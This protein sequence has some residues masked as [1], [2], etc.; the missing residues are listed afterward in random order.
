MFGKS[1]LPTEEMIALRA[2]DDNAGA[3]KLALCYMEKTNKSLEKHD[4]DFLLQ[5]AKLYFE[6]D[7]NELKAIDGYENHTANIMAVHPEMK[8]TGTPALN[9]CM[10]LIEKIPDNYIRYC[11]VLLLRGRCYLNAGEFDDAEQH[12]D[13]IISK[14]SQIVSLIETVVNAKKRTKF[15]VGKSLQMA[16]GM[17]RAYGEDRT[18]EEVELLVQTALAHKGLITYARDYD[19]EGAIRI[20]DMVLEKNHE[21]AVTQSGKK[22]LVKLSKNDIIKMKKKAR[23]S[24]V[25][26]TGIEKWALLM[27]NDIITMQKGGTGK[28]LTSISDMKKANDKAGLETVNLS[29]ME[30]RCICDC[31]CMNKIE[32]K[33]MLCVM[34]KDGH[35]KGKK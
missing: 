30:N 27:K 3:L 11:D 32:E 34:C 25:F 6:I 1:K 15:T 5:T 16:V 29:A 17:I 21:F 10:I 18:K 24:R 20:F 8:H 19:P 23:A 14:C 26:A 28:V 22:K 9:A 7:K 2:A 35:K 13:T 4:P 12:F 33:A 31:G